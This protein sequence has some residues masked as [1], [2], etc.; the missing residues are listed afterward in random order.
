MLQAALGDFIAQGYFSS[1][2]R[3]MR[4]LYGERQRL[5]QQAIHTHFP[6]AESDRLGIFVRGGDAGMHLVLEL[7]AHCDDVAISKEAARSS[8]TARAL[9][10]YY[11][12]PETALTGLVLGYAG[13]SEETIANAFGLLAAIIKAHLAVGPQRD[14]SASAAA[15]RRSV[16]LNALAWSGA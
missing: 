6:P 11:A 16:A 3:R 5:L 1:H 10:T 12:D 4:M 9:S 2:V 14:S 13:V 7:P 15:R 8:V